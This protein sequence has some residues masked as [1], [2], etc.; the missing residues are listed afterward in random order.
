MYLYI[1]AESFL[2][3]LN[4]LTKLILLFLSFFLCMIFEHP[5]FLLPHLILLFILFSFS[6]TLKNLKNATPFLL[7]LFLLSVLLWILFGRSLLYGIG[8]GMRISLMI[9]YGLLFLGCTKVEE[10][11][12]A[13][14]RI[15]VPYRVAFAFSLSF[16]LVP[17]LMNSASTIFEAQRAR[18]LSIEEINPIKRLLNY[19]PLIIPVFMLSLRKMQLLSFALEARGFGK[20]NRTFYRTWN[21]EKKDVF[22]IISFLFLNMFLI[23][24]RMKG[25]GVIK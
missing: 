4:P 14:L 22:Y 13:L 21:M 11:T 19:V 5:I 7:S 1:E 16:R 3:T 8:A 25:Y 10:F 24:L 17:T 9:G 6:K 2:H 18:G 15:H 12:W 23:Y 20:E